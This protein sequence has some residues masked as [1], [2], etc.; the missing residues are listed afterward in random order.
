MCGDVVAQPSQEGQGR[1]ECATCY[2]LSEQP[3]HKR[4]V[5][6]IEWAVNHRRGGWAVQ[7]FAYHGAYP[8]SGV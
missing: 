4:R 3:V 7:D 8:G 5:I 1:Y 6:Y 2:W